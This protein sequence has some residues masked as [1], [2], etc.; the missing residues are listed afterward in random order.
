[1]NECC[2]SQMSFLHHKETVMAFILSF[3]DMINHISGFPIW[4]HTGIPGINNFCSKCIICNILL[5]SICLDISLI[6]SYQY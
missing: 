6:L 4:N 5:D 3:I 1:M 2:I